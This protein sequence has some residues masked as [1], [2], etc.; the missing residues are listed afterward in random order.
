MLNIATTII[1]LRQVIAVVIFGVKQ[2]SQEALSP[3]YL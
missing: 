1:W 3:G 2:Y